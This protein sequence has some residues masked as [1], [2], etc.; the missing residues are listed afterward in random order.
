MTKRSLAQCDWSMELERV[1]LTDCELR[2]IVGQF[3]G[4]LEKTSSVTL[5]ENC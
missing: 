5:N 2:K 4:E 3:E 1:A